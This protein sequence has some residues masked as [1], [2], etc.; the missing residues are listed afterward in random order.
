MAGYLIANY[1]ITNPDGYR[2]YTAAVV[3]TIAAHSGRILVAG[4]GSE[5]VE[6]EPAPVTIVLEFPSKEALRGW[7]DS[8]E[9]QEI[10]HLRTDNTEGSMVFADEFTMPG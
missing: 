8:P 1:R 4:P 10:I 2:A 5:A 6:G 9:Y 7:Y 3:P